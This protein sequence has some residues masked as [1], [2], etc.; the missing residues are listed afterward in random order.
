MYNVRSLLLFCVNI[1]SYVPTFTRP[2]EYGR[3]FL[4]SGLSPPLL[5]FVVR[6]LLTVDKSHF[7][8]NSTAAQFSIGY[9]IQDIYD[10]IRHLIAHC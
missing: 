1:K 3:H 5:Q 10:L 4:I 8:T 6:S 2:V 7:K 9:P